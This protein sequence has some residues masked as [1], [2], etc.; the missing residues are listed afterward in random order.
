MVGQPQL[1]PLKMLHP[2]PK[3]SPPA[4]NTN[5]TH[6]VFLLIFY[7]SFFESTIKKVYYF[8]TGSKNKIN[9][10]SKN[11]ADLTDKRILIVPL[12]WGLGHATRCV[13]IIRELQ[14][15]GCEVIA[16]AEGKH[17]SLLQQEFPGMMILPLKGYRITY[18]RNRR[19]FGLHIIRQIPK[20]YSA[21][22]NEHKW[23]KK[24]IKE[25]KINAVISDNRFGLYHAGIPSVFIS[26]QLLIKTPYGNPVDGWLRMINY[27]YIR[28]Y[29]YCWI[30]D[31]EGSLSLAGELSHPQP[32][33]LHTQY[34]GCLSRFEKKE[35]IAKKYDLLVLISGPEPQRSQLETLIKEQII[36][37]N[38]SALIVSGQPGENKEHQ[39]TPTIRQVNHLGST[40]LNEAILA[41]DLVISRS[42]YTTVMDLVKLCKK[43]VLI[44]TPGQS[45]QE[46][47]GNYLMEKRIFYSTPQENFQLAS[48]LKAV[49][50]FP[51][52]SSPFS[53][54]MEAYKEIIHSFA[55]SLL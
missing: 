43:A 21:V 24:I 10:F 38:V 7:R 35:G 9:Y 16:G 15:A 17:A 2:V 37:L 6:F 22:Q 29:K 5:K 33:P 14:K 32:L 49:Q 45:E 51:F 1:L 27:H 20:I 44:P 13:P 23:L 42:G 26:H 50:T 55:A 36:S 41:A 3:H 53:D 8:L 30:P 52:H 12:D 48:A 34:L 28:R 25:H 4:N 46:Y 54:K 18:N 47:L 39:L 19:Y 31:F 40:S 11:Y